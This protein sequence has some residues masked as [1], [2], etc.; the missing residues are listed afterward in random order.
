M[1]NSG[2]F[3]YVTKQRQ[4]IT[5]GQH[6]SPQYGLERSHVDMNLWSRADALMPNGK[7]LRFSSIPA[8]N[9]ELTPRRP[10]RNRPAAGE[11]VI[12]ASLTAR[13]YLEARPVRP[14]GK[15]PTTPQP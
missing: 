1:L 9:Q 12:T 15:S 5:H 10:R 3:C 8:T 11:E 14:S 6:S 7:K 4:F 13:S 2:L